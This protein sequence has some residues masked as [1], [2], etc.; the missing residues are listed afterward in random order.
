MSLRNQTDELL[1]PLADVTQETEKLRLIAE[2][3]LELNEGQPL[4]HDLIQ[5]ALTSLAKLYAVNYQ[6]GD[7][8][9]P[10]SKESPVSATEA[11]ILVSAVLKTVNVEPFELGMWQA[12]AGA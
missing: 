3:I 10:L 8:V 5:R 2:E 12:W 7:R 6:K 4:T 9:S 1:D 11:L